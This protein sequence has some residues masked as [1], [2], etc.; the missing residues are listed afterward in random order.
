MEEKKVDSL[1]GKQIGEAALAFL[2]LVIVNL[3][4]MP[5]NLWIRSV[6]KLSE[7]RQQG[8][9][10]YAGKTEFPVLF[11]VRL[12]FDAVIFFVAPLVLLFGLIQFFRGFGLLEW[13]FK[14]WLMEAVFPLV[15][16]YLFPVFVSIMK[17]LFNLTLVQV[18]KI[19]KIEENTRK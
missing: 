10:N 3:F 1:E 6:K 12:V 18:M 16:A 14:M 5:I 7:I 13:G 15:A 17:E 4:I 19:E 11:W 9:M 8:L 2:F